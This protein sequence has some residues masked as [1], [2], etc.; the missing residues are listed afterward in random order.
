MESKDADFEESRPLTHEYHDRSEQQARSY[1]K[2]FAARL[3]INSYLVLLHITIV[4]LV[5][6]LMSETS[7][8]SP[9]P[10][11]EGISWSP[12]RNIVEY[13]VNGEHA[14]N[15]EV[16]SPYSGP[17]T[18]EQDQAWTHLI[19]PIFFSASA[20]ELERAGESLHNAV[21]MTEGGYLAT[22]SVYHEL[23][24]LRQ[25]RWFLYSDVFYPNRTMEEDKYLHGHLDHCLEA[26]RLSIMCHG[27]TGLYSF[28]WDDPEARQPTT[29]SNARSTCVKW[30]SIDDWARSRNGSIDPLLR[31]PLRGDH[32]AGS[33]S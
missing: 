22:I 31:W 8:T 6:V 21:Q 14:L 29:R 19:E 3:M 9:S 33:G 32:R 25:L 18:D 7:N 11:A 2:S 28:S 24:C 16:Y 1:G 5:V 27:N 15:H 23:H 17:P 12:A 26:L 20:E 4:A 13:E 10:A 30:S